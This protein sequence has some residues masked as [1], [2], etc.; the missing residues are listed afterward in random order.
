MAVAFAWLTT[1]RN[2]AYRSAMSLWNDTLA[3]RPQN[4]RAYNCRGVVLFEAGR[5][6]QAIVDYQTALRLRPEL[7]RRPGLLLRGPRPVLVPRR[8]PLLVAQRRARAAVRGFI[9]YLKKYLDGVQG[10]K[11]STVQGLKT[12]EDRV[13]NRRTR[14]PLNREP[15]NR[16]PE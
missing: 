11:G 7:Q 15:L 14:E 4:E 16:E 9:N 10:F 5:I 8:I 2:E 6:P 12:Q 3:K 1:A 13:V